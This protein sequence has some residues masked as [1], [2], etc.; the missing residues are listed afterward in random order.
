MFNRPSTSP[1]PKHRFRVRI[2]G[3]LADHWSARFDGI[4]VVQ[5]PEGDTLLTGEVADESAL[6]GIFHVIESIGAPVVSIFA[7]PAD[8]G[9]A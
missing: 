7:W 4:R 8:G 2:A 6:F 5:S 3:V 9:R 1:T